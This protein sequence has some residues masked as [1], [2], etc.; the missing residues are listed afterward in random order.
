M[1]KCIFFASGKGGTGKSTAVSAV[2]ACLAALGHR[3]VCI[4]MDLRLPNLDLIFG[5]SDITALDLIDVTEQRHTLE[6]VAV[7]HPRIGNLFLLAG[8]R[9]MRD[10]LDL[11]AL[12]KLIQQAKSAFDFVLVDTPAGV[13]ALFHLPAQLADMTLI[14]TTPDMASQRDAQR[15]VMELD[16]LGLA[17][18]RMIINRIRPVAAPKAAMDIDDVIDFVGVPLLGLVPEDID[19]TG[20][21]LRQIALVLHSRRAAAVA[22]L[23]VT[24]RILGRADGK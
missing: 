24:K 13:D 16:A 10:L 3:T 19:V 15:V 1:G 17:D 12:E 11:A 7:E 5:M 14:I 22:F 6:S 18:M 8:P 20:A 2:G 9:A 23:R 21:A 4:D